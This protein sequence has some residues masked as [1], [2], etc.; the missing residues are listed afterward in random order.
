MT[1]SGRRRSFPAS[2]M[3]NNSSSA[4]FLGRLSARSSFISPKDVKVTVQLLNDADSVTNEFKRSQTA[5]AILDYICE[6][7]SI[8]E[9][10]YLGLRYQDH[11]KHR[12]GVASAL[13]F[14]SICSFPSLQYWV[15]LSRPISHIVKQ[16]KSDSIALRLRFRYYPAEPSHLRENVSRFVL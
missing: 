1:A 4:S 12:V 10:D 16:F 11:N 14:F 2:S 13:P 8:H 7:K 5:Q 3:P 15:D 9:K 6:V